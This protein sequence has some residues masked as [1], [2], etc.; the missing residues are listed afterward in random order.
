M[1]Q[2]FISWSGGVGQKVGAALHEWLPAVIQELNPFFSPQIDKGTFWHNEISN[3]LEAANF[4]IVCITEESVRSPWLHYEA[5]ALSQKL[6]T[7]E[8]PRVALFLHKVEYASLTPPLQALQG[9]KSEIEQSVWDLVVTINK[10]CTSPLPEKRLRESFDLTYPRLRASLESIEA[11]E[12]EG[13]SDELENDVQPAADTELKLLLLDL[14]ERVSAMG[15]QLNSLDRS[16]RHYRGRTLTDRMVVDMRTD[17]GIA[18]QSAVHKRAMRLVSEYGLSSEIQESEGVV[19]VDLFPRGTSEVRLANRV[20]QE[21]LVY[22]PLVRVRI[23][24][25]GDEQE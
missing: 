9:T 13:P 25:E 4:G 11:S 16:Q 15:A 8:E 21:L 17:A 6:K 22:G 5:G 12:E 18:D 7:R 24:R 20:A 10:Q 14:S 23:R 3:N 1:T 19:R 2:I